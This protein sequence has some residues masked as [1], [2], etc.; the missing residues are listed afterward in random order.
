MLG[1]VCLFMVEQVQAECTF[2]DVPGTHPFYDEITGICELGITQGY[3]DGTYRPTNNITR[4]AMAAFSMRTVELLQAGE[5]AG[6]TIGCAA[7][8]ATSTVLGDDIVVHTSFVLRNFNDAETIDIDR[9][10]IY[11]ADGTVRCDFPGIN[12][13]PAT[14]KTS[15]SPHQAMRLFT[16]EISECITPQFEGSIQA[17][18]SWSV[19]SGKPVEPLFVTSTGIHFNLTDNETF[20]WAPVLCKPIHPK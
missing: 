11:D 15:L 14:F 17:I 7:Q 1:F 20:G 4:A 10:I 5:F 16:A 19:P 12:S 18:I 8:V 13:F 6:G 9:L 2:S 3:D